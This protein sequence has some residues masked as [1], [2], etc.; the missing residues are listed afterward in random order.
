MKAEEMVDASLAGFDQSELV[1]LLSLPDVADWQAYEAARQKLIPNLS[2]RAP[3]A[4][5]RQAAHS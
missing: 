3:A 4:R 5:Y 2:L 1:T